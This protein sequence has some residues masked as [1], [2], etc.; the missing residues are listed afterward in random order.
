MR[1]A[2][3]LSLAIV[4]L[5][6]VLGRSQQIAVANPN[7]VWTSEAAFIDDPDPGDPFNCRTTFV[8]DPGENQIIGRSQL[9][10]NSSYLLNEGFNMN[11]LWYS[12]ESTRSY[13][14]STQWSDCGP[15]RNRGANGACGHPIGNRFFP[16]G[17]VFP[18]P[19]PLRVFEFGNSFIVRGCGNYGIDRSARPIPRISGYKYNDLNGN[20]TWDGGEPPL[21]NWVIRL[22]NSSGNVRTTSTNG[23]GYYEFP[24]DG[25]GPDT[26]SLT[27]DLQPG[28]VAKQT[29]GPIGVGFGIGDFR[30]ENNNFG[31]YQLASTS[32]RKF[33][34]L[35]GNGVDDGDPAVTAPSFTINLNGTTGGGQPVSLSTGT[36]PAG[37]YSFPNLQPGNYTISEVVP[38]GWSQ[39]YPTPI[40][41][42][43]HGVLLQSGQ[44]ASGKDFGNWRPA[45]V[46]GRKFEDLN[47]N[48]PD[49]SDPGVAG[50]P[51]QLTGTDGLGNP[52]GP[53]MTTTAPDGTY[54]FGNLRPGS[55]QLNEGT[56]PGWQQSYPLPVPPGQHNFTLQSGENELGRDF[57]NYRFAQ[58]SGRKYEDMN[59]DGDDETGADPGVQAW[60]IALQGV[61]GFGAPVSRTATTDI[62]GDYLFDNVVPGTYTVTEVQQSGWNAK[63]GVAGYPAAPISG[64]QIMNLRFGNWRYATPSG[65]KYD[66]LNGNGI[67]DSGEPGLSG[68]TIT[69][70]GTDG[71]G[72]SVNRT[73]TTIAD[74]SYSFVNVVPGTYTV[75]E[76]SQ[77]GWVQSQPASGT[78][79]VVLVSN[80]VRSD[81]AFGNLV[82][83][84]VHGMKFQDMNEN[85]V[86]DPSADTGL[87]GWTI[88]LA[89]TD[90]M[91]R[92]VSLT[93]TTAADG[94]YSFVGIWPGIA[95]AVCETNPDPVRWYQ[96]YPG[97]DGCNRFPLVSHQVVNNVDFGNYDRSSIEGIKYSDH[98]KDG[99]KTAGDE[100]LPGWT[101]TLTDCNGNVIPAGA[102][103][104]AD[105][106]RTDLRSQPSAD[107][108]QR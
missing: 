33:E 1:R 38:G 98:H 62:S 20:G 92:P 2:I 19:V 78:Y 55:Y 81:L 40:P 26:Y 59:A 96:T 83:A 84:E 45:S 43:T 63:E 74:G 44:N 67:R 42:G 100:T 75:S 50:W 17:D 41:P 28:W 47:A 95:Y 56:Q 32:G 31:N 70:A 77:S 80:Q 37:N 97:G 10:A 54:S 4:S 3:F 107:R 22:Y 66:D 105:S 35:N 23:G 25:L 103:R 86:K 24:L 36:D 30:F 72:M 16:M 13:P 85:G 18:S 6:T 46:S 21:A 49:P 90:G 11:F 34:D 82:L 104:D 51:I 29:P 8:I 88:T 64:Q 71:M 60:T 53:L 58:I 5:L 89:G 39:S 69:L 93:T 27:E 102:E 79:G 91:G 76:T 9:L 87:G 14:G 52:V 101:V 61:D 94:S 73:E 68:W 108:R 106:A 15:P 65:V 99:A 48:G 12:Y 7:C 57:G